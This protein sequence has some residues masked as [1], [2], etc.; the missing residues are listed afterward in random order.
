MAIHRGGGQRRK[1]KEREI[2][3]T[4]NEG[5]IIKKKEL[6]KGRRKEKRMKGKKKREREKT[7][8]GGKEREEKHGREG[9]KEREKTT[10]GE[11]EERTR[12]EREKGDR[13]R[14]SLEHFSPNFTIPKLFSI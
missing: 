5:K 12:K 13:V 14:V 9:K 8:K 10:K 3:K 11:N 4:R 6:I 7:R 1:E 2:E